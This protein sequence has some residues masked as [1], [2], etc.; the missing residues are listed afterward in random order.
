MYRIDVFTESG[1]TRFVLMARRSLKKEFPSAN[2]VHISEGE[3]PH[4][5]GS[6]HDNSSSLS[7]IPDEPDLEMIDINYPQ[8]TEP[9]SVKGRLLSGES[10]MQTSR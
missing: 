6:S 4:V 1:C 7:E 8:Q 2:S 10:P 9:M 3:I 5:P